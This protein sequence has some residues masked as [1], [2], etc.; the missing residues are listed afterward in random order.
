[1]EIQ[2]F[3]LNESYRLIQFIA[4]LHKTLTMLKNLAE[5]HFGEKGE[6]LTKN[7]IKA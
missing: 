7:L 4:L 6:K 3:L 5:K 2:T 1:M